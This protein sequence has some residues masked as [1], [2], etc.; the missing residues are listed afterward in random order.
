[1]SDETL[2]LTAEAEAEGPISDNVV[3]APAMARPDI[4]PAQLV[5]IIPLL[6]QFLNAFGVYHL[7]Q[8]Q[9]DSLMAL[10]LGAIG[11][12]GADAVIRLGRSLSLKR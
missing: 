3:L 9:Q 6:A 7:S 2:D 8:A 12:F 5:G 11:L 4:T 1:M 10:T